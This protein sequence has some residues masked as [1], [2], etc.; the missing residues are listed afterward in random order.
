MTFDQILQQLVDTTAGTYGPFEWSAAYFRQTFEIFM[1]S[2][3]G[4]FSPE[5]ILCITIVSLLKLRLFNCDRWIPPYATALVG[6]IVAVGLALYQFQTLRMSAEPVV[7]EFFTGLMIY[8]QFTV[9]FRLLL[10]IF[11][12]LVVALTVVSGIPD[13]DDGPDFYTLLFGAAVGMMMM[14]G[15]NHLLIL[16][17]SI[18]MASVPSYA[19]VGFLKGRRPSSEA[20][21]KYVVYGAGS[22]GVMLYGLSLLTGLL[23]T[24]TLISVDGSTPDLASRLGL[25]LAG[26][27][28]GTAASLVSN[29][30][31]TIL[32]AILMVF[33]GLAFKLSIVPFHFWCPDA[34]EGAA[35]EVGGFLSVA[36]KAGAFALLVRFCIALTGNP[37]PS[38]AGLNLSLGIGLGVAAAVTATF[39][40][41]AAYS[42]KNMKRLLAYSTIAHAGYMLMAVSALVIIRG[43]NPSGV[44]GLTSAGLDA[45]ARRCLEALLYYLAVYLFMNLGAFAIVA[46]IRNQIFSEEIEDYRGLAGEA[47]V[48]CVCMLICLFSLV[49]LP[50]LGGFWAKLEI[51]ASLFQAGRVH[52]FMWVVLGIAAVNT[53]FSLFY[54]M[55]VL[56]S[57]FL[58][59]RPVGARSALVPFRSA[60]GLYVVMVSVP[61]LLLGVLAGP[62]S[63]TANN[64]ARILLR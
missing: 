39:G 26:N 64:V 46:L 56:K 63:Q 42:Q 50:P 19:M 12:V 14:A 30:G 21:L 17:L 15:A 2:S 34:F 3:L 6:S 47:P 9:Y 61:V 22:A 20:S 45:E 38:L 55:R 16:F 25:V 37:D 48:L 23:G 57:M 43:A 44:P 59:E 4:R 36:S 49:G 31:L 28:A 53:V 41:L 13:R 60:P 33:V 1:T 51:F 32:L 24:A 27:T 5:I 18:E 40:N 58:T 62:L 10:L 54:Y 52:W 7:A 11:L 35:A 8:D 29:P